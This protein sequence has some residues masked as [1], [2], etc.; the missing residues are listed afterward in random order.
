MEK[1]VMEGEKEKCSGLVLKRGECGRPREGQMRG[2]AGRVG[3]RVRWLGG[4]CCLEFFEGHLC[5][6]Q[7]NLFL[8]VG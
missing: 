3:L 8:W 6:S 7:R 1:A 2:Q 5:W 4:G